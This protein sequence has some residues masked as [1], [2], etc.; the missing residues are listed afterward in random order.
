MMASRFTTD[1]FPARGQRNS[2]SSFNAVHQRRRR[3]TENVEMWSARVDLNTCLSSRASVGDKRAVNCWLDGCRAKVPDWPVGGNA[4]IR[5]EA[6]RTVSP[7]TPPRF[8]GCCSSRISWILHNKTEHFQSANQIHLQLAGRFFRWK[9]ADQR[10]NVLTRY[11]SRPTSYMRLIDSLTSRACNQHQE[12]KESCVFL[13]KVSDICNQR[14]IYI[15][16]LKLKLLQLL[17]NWVFLFYFIKR[18][19]ASAYL[20]M[21]LSLPV[22]RTRPGEWRRASFRTWS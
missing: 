10:Q 16:T 19:M 8:A 2:I 20:V 14:F 9:A 11:A 4:A 1:P 6:L 18:I 17:A 3:S 22:E 21:A 15:Q 5:Q 7:E 13:T 12:E